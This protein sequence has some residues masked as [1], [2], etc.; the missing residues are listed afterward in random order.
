MG[1]N[2]EYIY[3]EKAEKL[4]SNRGF[5]RDVVGVAGSYGLLD[6][7]RIDKGFLGARIVFAIFFGVF[8]GEFFQFSSDVGKYAARVVSQP[9]VNRVFNFESLSVRKSTELAFNSRHGGSGGSV[10]RKLTKE[11]EVLI[12]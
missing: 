7:A 6:G 11:R 2:L 9:G 1:I 5:D 8:P 12:V 10:F 4:F 3:E